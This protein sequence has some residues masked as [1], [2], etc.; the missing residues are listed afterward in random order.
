MSILSIGS[1]NKINKNLESIRVNVFTSDS[2]GGEEYI[3]SIESYKTIYLNVIGTFTGSLEVAG[4]SNSIQSIGSQAP[5]VFTN[6][7]TKE[8]ITSNTSGGT[9]YL[10]EEGL[11]VAN[12]S[13]QYEIRFKTSLTSGT[14]S[15]TALLSNEAEIGY[16]NFDKIYNSYK[17]I[18][19]NK[20]D[21]GQVIVKKIENYKTVYLNISGSFEGELRVL[22]RV[23]NLGSYSS[24]PNLTFTNLFNGETPLSDSITRRV[25]IT[26]AGLYVAN[27]SPQYELR[28]DYVVSNGAMNADLIL[29]NEEDI[30]PFLE[31][32]IRR[33]ET[34]L[35]S[36]KL[37]SIEVPANTTLNA[38]DKIDASRFD[39]LIIIGGVQDGASPRTGIFKLIPQH[40]LGIIGSTSNI[41]HTF[42]AVPGKSV[43][44]SGRIDT[45]GTVFRLSIENNTNNLV[46]YHY[47]IIGVK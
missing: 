13:P 24:E 11:Y 44:N 25:K 19:S 20:S 26:E 42:E 39:Q 27:I 15:V 38:L 16:V 2:G 45:L 12:I 23:K 40:N 43:I 33:S 14:V 47:E 22:G 4:V 36:Y 18:I 35:E 37:G 29:V 7:K 5:L 21:S 6:V 31:A 41:T 1:L 3:T 17:N 10:T 32:K 9:V 28:F 46:T 8:T 34:V 30:Y